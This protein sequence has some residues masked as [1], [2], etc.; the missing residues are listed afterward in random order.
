[1]VGVG[2]A[3]SGLFLGSAAALLT[4]FLLGWQGFVN[5]YMWIGILLALAAVTERPGRSEA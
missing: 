5:Y 1:M 4:T 3:I 2:A